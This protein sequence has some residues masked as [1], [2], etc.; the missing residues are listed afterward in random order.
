[1]HLPDTQYFLLFY[2]IFLI[3]IGAAFIA[4]HLWFKAP[5]YLLWMGVGCILPSVALAAQTLMTNAQL[6]QVAPWFAL[7]YL[8]GACAVAHGMFLKA[9]SKTNIF[10]TSVI[11]TTA[12]VL[13][14]YFTHID[15]QLWVRIII[16]NV[17]ILCLEGLAIPTVYLLLKK[18]YP[19]EK[20]LCF[21][22]FSLFTYGF[23][24]TLTVI[25]YLQKVQHID[26]A[27]TRWWMMMIAVN[28]L[29]S[30]CFAIIVSAVAIREKFNIINEE[31]LRDPLTKLYNRNG[32]LEKTKDFFNKLQPGEVYLV[33]CDIDN[34]K[35]I[36]DTWGHVAGDSILCTI[37]DMCKS[38]IRQTDIIGRFG[39]EEFVILLQSVD[40]E[41]SVTLVDRLRKN[42]EDHIFINN[43]RITAS[44]GIAIIIDF[45]QLDSAL[46]LADRRLYNAKNSGRNRVCFN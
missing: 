32:F 14:L 21:S 4:A 3:L 30:L 5:R 45:S 6:R 15:D 37:A 25:I 17:V 41:S 16:I 34:F 22:Y 36:N 10:L 46:E 18:T 29:L 12:M 9:N 23:I 19:L 28:L 7:F 39:G 20:L 13:L 42:I 31:R 2:P 24:R 11:I 8:G 43:I 27:T 33:M 40:D 44:F 1:M 35:N 26:L 38:N